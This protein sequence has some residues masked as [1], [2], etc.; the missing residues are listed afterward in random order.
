VE[1][2]IKHGIGLKI[3]GGTI[4]LRSRL[5]RDCL[6]LEVED[7]GVGMSFSAASSGNGSGIGMSNV[8]ERL[9]VLYGN[10][11]HMRVSSRDGVGTLITLELPL[12]DSAMAEPLAFA[13]D[14]R[15]STSR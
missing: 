10:S 12:V 2:S 1:N 9:K 4:T 6:T 8:A 5:A 13:Q 11:A 14:A 7:D 3:E 15:S